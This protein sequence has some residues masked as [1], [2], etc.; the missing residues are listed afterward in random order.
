MVRD[1]MPFRFYFSF[2]SIDLFTDRDKNMYVTHPEVDKIEYCVVN[3]TRGGYFC[4]VVLSCVRRREFNYSEGTWQCHDLEMLSAS[5]CFTNSRVKE[6]FRRISVIIIKRIHHRLAG[7]ITSVNALCMGESI[8]KQLMN[9]CRASNIQLL[10]HFVTCNTWR[11][12]QM[13]TFSA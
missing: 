9:F 11:R 4:A 5:D 3:S 12:N 6:H 1:K 13:E 7:K 10:Y 2:G 8:S